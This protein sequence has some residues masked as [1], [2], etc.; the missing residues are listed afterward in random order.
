MSGASEAGNGPFGLSSVGSRIAKPLRGGG[1][2]VVGNIAM[3]T[4]ANGNGNAN[5]AGPASPTVAGLQAL[6][7]DGSNGKRASWFSSQRQWLSP[8][9]SWS[10]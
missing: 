5:H 9:T 4:G 3:D 10:S 8:T 1:A 7:K 6:D 2:S